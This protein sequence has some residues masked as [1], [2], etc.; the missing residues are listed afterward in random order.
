MI[1][2]SLQFTVHS[3][4]RAFVSVAIVALALTV[5]SVSRLTPQTRAQ[6]G[7]KVSTAPAGEGTSGA[8]NIVYPETKKDATV[9]DYFGTKVADPYRWLEG[10]ASV[11]P[12]VASW[13]EAENKVTFAYLRRFLFAR[14]SKSA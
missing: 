6:K 1:S 14:R 2:K 7:Q 10:D 3:F 12:Q 13:V 11:S 8:P 5:L 9:D 4:P